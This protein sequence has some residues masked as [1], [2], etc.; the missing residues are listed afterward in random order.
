[1]RLSTLQ[2]Q[3][4]ITIGDNMFKVKTVKYDLTKLILSIYFSFYKEVETVTE[5]R[6]S[7]ELKKIHS[8]GHLYTHKVTFSKS[9]WNL[10]V[11]ELDNYFEKLKFTKPI[12]ITNNVVESITTL[13]KFLSQFELDTVRN[14][15]MLLL[16]IERHQLSTTDIIYFK[17]INSNIVI[18]NKLITKLNELF[19]KE[20]DDIVSNNH[21]VVFNT[22]DALYFRLM[23]T[24][25]CTIEILDIPDTPNIAESQAVELE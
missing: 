14:R 20:I 12:N 7:D 16:K 11:D 18:F 22:D 9:E 19:D 13:D 5:T 24:L 21:R 2:E 8:N 6:T 3:K 10:L 1:M 25:K 23:Q 4:M 17:D 15:A